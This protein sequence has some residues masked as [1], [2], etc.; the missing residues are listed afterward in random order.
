M[1]SASGASARAR[2]PWPREVPMPLLPFLCL[3]LVA[4]AACSSGPGRHAGLARTVWVDRWDYRTPVDIERVLEDCRR[5]GFTAVMFQVRGNGT[6]CYPGGN[7]VW[8]ET[9][10]FRDP[11][12]DPLVTAVRAAHARGLQL[13]AW[14]NAMPGWVG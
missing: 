13:H 7:E 8:S 6:L 12:F 5:D 14:I 10:H 9:F 2:L 1:A 3:S 4:I 11:G